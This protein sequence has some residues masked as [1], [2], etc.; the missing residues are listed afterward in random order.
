MSFLSIA[1][2]FKRNILVAKQCV[3]GRSLAL[4][5]GAVEHAVLMQEELLY[6]F[7][8]GPFVLIRRLR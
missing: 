4:F 2:K 8:Q 1:R 3:L 7:K 6:N 5:A